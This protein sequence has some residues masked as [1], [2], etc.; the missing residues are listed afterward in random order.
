MEWRINLQVDKTEQTP[1]VSFEQSLDELT[2]TDTEIEL[3]LPVIDEVRNNLNRKYVEQFLRKYSIFT[4]DIS[5][6]FQIADDIN[7]EAVDYDDADTVE[8]TF[9]NDEQRHGQHRYFRSSPNNRRKR[10]EQ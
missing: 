6:K 3:V 10:M 7:P 9:N 8:N 1:H 2:H 4:T 5:F